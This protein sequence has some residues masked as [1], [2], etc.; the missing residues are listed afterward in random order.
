MPA[1]DADFLMFLLH[2]NPRVPLDPNTK[3]PVTKLKERVATLVRTLEKTR[4]K[5]V[6]PTPALSEALAIA[7]DK[8]SDYLAEL[9][10]TYGFEMAAFDT[11][12]AVEAAI[13]TADAKKRGGGKKGSSTSTWAKIKF[14]RQIIAIAKVRGITTIYSNDE[15]IR[16]AGEREQ[17]KVIAAWDLPEPPP[18]QAEMFEQPEK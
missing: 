4:D 11:V 13:A 2:K 15:D 12:A 8:A 6:I 10:N 9:T 7:T 3:Q 17:I 1:F 5:I 16:K 18:E 14:D